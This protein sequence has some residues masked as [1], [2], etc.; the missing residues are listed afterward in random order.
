MKNLKCCIQKILSEKSNIDWLIILD[1]SK[2]YGSTEDIVF[3]FVNAE[4]R[5]DNP[6]KTNQGY[7]CLNT[8]NS[9]TEFRNIIAEL[10][11]EF[12]GD[13]IALVNLFII[14]SRA[15]YDSEDILLDNFK[16]ML[17]KKTSKRIFE[18]LINSLNTE[19]FKHNSS[20]KHILTD[21]ESWLKLLHA[22]QYSRDHSDILTKC[23]ILVRNERNR[24]LD[25]HLIENMNPLMRS[26][27]IGFYGFDLKI[28]TQKLKIIHE[29]ERELAFL[30]AILIDDYQEGKMPPQWLTN[31]LIEKFV[32][33]HWENIGKHCFIHAYGLSYRNKV[34]N[35]VYSK[36]E[37]LIHNALYLELQKEQPETKKWISQLSFPHDFIALFSWFTNAKI[38]YG[39]LPESN[40]SAILNRFINELESIRKNLP[41]SLVSEINEDPFYSHQIHETKYQNALAH[42]LFL[43]LYE[44]SFD[45]KKLKSICFQFKHLFYGGYKAILMATRF[46]EVMVLIPLNI[47]NIHGINDDF[48][49]KN[50]KVYLSILEETVLIPYFHLIERQD[51]IWN[52]ES[53]KQSFQFNS[54][55]YL[56]TNA[57]IKIKQSPILIHYESLFKIL[58]DVKISRLAYEN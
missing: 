34:K 11:E 55:R 43:M 3:S 35:G 32:L 45:S 20:I 47:I 29:D 28:S 50:L 53:E 33:K 10:N 58:E 7:I 5:D 40:T 25:F 4:E 36:V 31:V 17:E 54:G 26:M 56:I 51:D 14:V 6:F 16:K 13:D 21:T 38:E 24:E 8:P 15:S 18:L 9:I 30:A 46:T 52:L 44:D 27:L 42:L 2:A 41:K 12:E 57:I 19:Y 1:L 48:D 37:E 49:Y 23:L 22:S 39:K